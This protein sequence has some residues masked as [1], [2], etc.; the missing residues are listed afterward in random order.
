MTRSNP[1]LT[2]ISF[3]NESHFQTSLRSAFWPV[4]ADHH[5]PNHCSHPSMNKP[6]RQIT[7]TRM[8][9]NRFD[10]QL[11]EARQ[12]LAGN[13][14]GQH[15]MA[16]SLPTGTN[17]VVNGDFETFT[18]GSDT[19]Y[20]ESEITGWRAKHTLAGRQFNLI[21]VPI[22]YGSVL[23]LDSNAKNFD[24][25]FQ[26]VPTQPGKQ[27]LLSFDFNAHSGAN[28]GKTAHSYDFEVWWNGSHIK[29]ITAGSIWETGVLRVTGGPGST[30]ELLFCEVQEGPQGGGDGLG[31]LL[32]NV[33]VVKSVGSPTVNGSFETT[34]GTSPL[35]LAA[36]VPG[37]NSIATE[38]Q[39]RL[40]RVEQSSGATPKTQATQ[41]SQF[42]NLDTSN[43]QRDAVFQDL[44]TVNG[45][46]YYVSFDARSDGSV[47][48][49][50]DEL[51]VRWNNAWATTIRAASDWQSYG[52]VVRANSSLSR[53]MLLEP[54]DGN[55]GEG[56]GPCIDNLRV[57][58]IDPAGVNEAPT[59]QQLSNQNAEFGLAKTIAV[60]ATDPEN[61]ALSYSILNQTGIPAGHNLPTISSAGVVNW[62]PSNAGSVA[63][64]IR[65]TDSLGKF[66]DMTF[67]VTVESFVP[68]AGKRAL[69]AVPLQFR[70]GIYQ[71]AGVPAMGI[72]TTKNFEARFN[73]TAGLL[74]VKLFAS[75]SPAT[76]NSF[77][78]LARDGFYDGV[79]F[80]RVLAGF[81][82]QGGDPTGT[83]TGGPG[84]QFG[85][86][87]SNGLTFNKPGLLAMA[88]AGPGT[89]G[90]QFFFTYGTPTSLNGKHTIFG[91]IIGSDTALQNLVVTA[92]AQPNGTEVP[93]TGITKSIINSITI[94]V[95]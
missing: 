89:N 83:G 23:D 30:T 31:A 9:A 38:V 44:T 37:W 75:L 3:P 2:R 80:H 41:G 62:T 69:S 32:D 82:A 73:T 87:T 74:T 15:Q 13:F 58:R 36:D 68:F 18:A 33:R 17:L 49:R 55:N 48:D 8:P 57:F 28:P 66:S 47:S 61:Q 20:G 16:E 35:K 51:R 5:S 90:S 65:A 85:D 40:L 64:T 77:V 14:V 76:V 12:L 59:V 7:R 43:T 92:D 91:E 6:A 63:L 88:N 84:Y 54:G 67:N 93:R 78:S 60:T 71:T 22:G 53:L 94:H 29:T 26:N 86:E 24:R 10:F 27:Y 21:N 79:N 81:A 19:F 25:V 39:K 11:L 4:F 45:A 52:I 56:S 72:D 34:T 42:L 46:V 50:S 95:T 1:K 70:T